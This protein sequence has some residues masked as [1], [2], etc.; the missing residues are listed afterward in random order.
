VETSLRPSSLR[1]RSAILDAAELI[2]LR[3]GYAT[4]NMDELAERSGVSKQTIYSHFGSK[5]TLFV[6]MA[7]RMTGVGSDRVHLEAVGPGD[8]EQMA[9][10]LERY[11]LRLLDSVLDPHLVALRRLVIGEA[12]R[13]PDLAR[14]FWV[15][16]PNRS[17]QAMSERFARLTKLGVLET[18]DPDVAAQSFNWL[19]MATPLNAAMMLGDAALP[20]PTER[21][22]IA[23]E[24]T[25]VFLA[26]YGT[27]TA[28]TTH[29]P[30]ETNTR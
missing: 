11:A 10:Y 21:R 26:A 22:Q 1:K 18:P 16:G 7:T 27:A 3:D 30:Y 9:D 19:V 29:R 8:A 4:A 12:S 15:N 20:G 23:E 25:R 28:T 13:F 24:A 2:F 6:E 17:M 5:R 14:A